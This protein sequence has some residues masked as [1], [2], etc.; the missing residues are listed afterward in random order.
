VDRYE[1]GEEASVGSL[2]RIKELAVQMKAALLRG[3]LD[4]FGVLLHEEWLTKKRLSDRISTPHL[5]A[6]YEAAR[7][8]GALGGKVA[9]AGG[10]GFI[11]LYCPFDRKHRIAQRLRD[12]GC[13]IADFSF[14]SRGVQTWSVP[15]HS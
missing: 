10:G 9:G 11:V 6:L 2:R 1:R 15:D 5:E 12:M 13:S 14:T 3:Q 4:E 7:V 8:E